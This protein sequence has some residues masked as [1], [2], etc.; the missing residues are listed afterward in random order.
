LQSFLFINLQNV[1]KHVLSI[2]VISFN[3][4]L[5]HTGKIHIE[6]TLCNKIIFKLYYP[7]LVMT[8]LTM[9]W[10]P[11]IPKVLFT[12]HNGFDTNLSCFETDKIKVS[13]KH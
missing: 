9:A 10:N 12:C 4:C 8:S 11:D 6:T 3:N 7:V 13:A 2:R 1:A 5:H